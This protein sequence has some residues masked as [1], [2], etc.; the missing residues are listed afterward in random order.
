MVGDIEMVWADSAIDFA[1]RSRRELGNREPNGRGGCSRMQH[2]QRSPARDPQAPASISGGPA[3]VWRR[4]LLELGER[5]MPHRAIARAQPVT[6]LRSHYLEAIVNAVEES[7]RPA[8]RRAYEGAWKRF[9][10]WAEAEGLQPLPADPMTVAAYLINRAEQGLS[11]STLSLDRKAISHFHRTANLPTPTISEGVKLTLAGLRNQAAE[12]G[13]GEPQQAKG[14]TGERLDAI[15]RTAHR[16]R[17]GQTGRKE[18]KAAALRRGDVDIA[19]ATV[20][21]DALLRRSEAAEL[22]WGDVEF[23]ADGS[24]LITIRRSKTSIVSAVQYVGTGATGA[25]CRIRPLNAHPDSRVFGLR[26]GRSISNRLGAMA[27][28]AGLGEGFSGHSPRVGM[29]QDL[30]AAGVGLAALMVAGRWRSERMPAH[31]ARGEA[32]RRGAVAKFHGEGSWAEKTHRSR[33]AG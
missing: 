3:E 15:I 23:S 19:I 4:W 26:S 8:T 25:L 28:E 17:V 12:Q 14:L 2:S 6:E 7:R 29:A 31:Y 32:A 1:L 13:R 11:Q 22:R 10:S 9:R 20:M 30:T 18:S 24:S 5:R 16:Q 21:R 33:Q 27:R